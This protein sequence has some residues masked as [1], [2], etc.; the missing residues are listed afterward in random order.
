MHSR[1][2]F[3]SA[4]FRKKY[5][6][7]SSLAVSRPDGKSAFN[8]TVANVI[9][10]PNRCTGL[11]VGSAWEPHRLSGLSFASSNELILK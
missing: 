8:A 3:A 11:P 1:S 6:K 5:I 7:L 9:R 2:V 4:N 10:G